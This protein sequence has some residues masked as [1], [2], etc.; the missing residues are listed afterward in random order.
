MGDGVHKINPE[1]P[2]TT[3]TQRHREKQKQRTSNAKQNLGKYPANS[4]LRVWFFSVSL[5]LCGDRF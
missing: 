2:F 1:K 3:E 5:C 4:K